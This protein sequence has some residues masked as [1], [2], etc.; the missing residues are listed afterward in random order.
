MPPFEPEDDRSLPDNSVLPEEGERIDELAARLIV[1]RTSGLRLK[2]VDR[3]PLQSMFDYE[4]YEDHRLIGCLEVGRHTDQRKTRSTQAFGQHALEPIETEVLERSWSVAFTS[5]A[6]WK[7]LDT[8]LVPT[9]QDLEYSGVFEFNLQQHDAWRPGT[10]ASLLRS[11]HALFAHS[12]ESGRGPRKVSVSKAASFSSRLQPD[13][14]VTT[15]A[16]WLNSG[17]KDPRGIRRKLA[18]GSGPQ[19]HAFIWIDMNGNASSWRALWEGSPS[20]APTLPAEVNSLWLVTNRGWW[21]TASSG[22]VE[23]ADVGDAARAAR[24]AFGLDGLHDDSEDNPT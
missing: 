7:R 22:W 4:L 8:W 14:A 17:A 21:W 15:N 1:E 3:P 16:D 11:R 20:R 13:D 23:T 2:F 5:D 9:L 19:R 18:S 12:Y 6:D 24:L 10:P